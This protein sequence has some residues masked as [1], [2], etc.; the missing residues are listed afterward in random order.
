M[1]QKFYGTHALFPT[2]PLNK[3]TEKLLFSSYYFI[4][5]SLI[6]LNADFLD[7]LILIIM[8]FIVFGRLKNCSYIKFCTSYLPLKMEFRQLFMLQF[9]IIVQF[10]RSCHMDGLRVSVL[11]EN[12]LFHSLVLVHC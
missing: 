3:Y 8:N 11:K 5:L 1:L 6:E 2:I 4:R 7:R 10:F 12:N 9:V